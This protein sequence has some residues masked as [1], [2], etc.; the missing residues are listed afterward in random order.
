MR[1]RAQ[2]EDSY[3]RI[4]A[5][6]WTA[7]LQAP[8]STGFPRQGT[9][10]GCRFLLQAVF[11]TQGSKLGVL[12][13]KQSPALQADFLP[14]DPARKPLYAAIRRWL[15]VETRVWKRQRVSPI[16]KRPQGRMAPSPPWFQTFILRNLERKHISIAL[17]HPVCEP[18]FWLP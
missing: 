5:A 4:A 10:V 2:R 9:R 6:T 12:Y 13:H 7:A 17:R 11:P 18:L 15:S 14:T 1:K 16:P 3:V 8:L